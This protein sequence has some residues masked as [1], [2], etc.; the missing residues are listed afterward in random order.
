MYNSNFIN[1]SHESIWR[2]ELSKEIWK[3]GFLV[4]FYGGLKIQFSGKNN[5]HCGQNG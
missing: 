5:R 2:V 4:V 1:I 3:F